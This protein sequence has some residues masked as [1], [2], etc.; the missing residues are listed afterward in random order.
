MIK[1]NPERKYFTESMVNLHTSIVCALTPENLHI[2]PNAEQASIFAQ[3]H[4]YLI[5]RRPAVAFDPGSFSFEPPLAQGYLTRKINGKESRSSFKAK[6]GT[7]PG[8]S[9]SVAPYPHR[10]ILEHDT[11]G[12]ETG[13]HFPIS[14]ICHISELEDEDIRNFEVVYVGQAFGK[15]GRSAFERLKNHSTLQRILAESAANRPD[16]ELMLFLFKYEPYQIIS[17]MDGITKDGEKGDQDT[18]HFISL[19]KNPLS[20][21]QQIALAEAG[22]IRYF[23]PEYNIVYKENFPNENQTI[24][25]QCYKLDF[26]ALSVEINT[27]DVRSRLWSPSVD[28]GVH[29]IAKFD[30][31]DIAKR[32]SFF[33]FV[34][35]DGRQHLM[36]EGGPFY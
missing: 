27:E 28:L 35:L 13:I 8:G 17:M 31:H 18:E 19:L 24:L 25:D 15:G 14:L 23:R 21:K 12:N 9:L 16:D 2:K 22:L 10:T 11:T 3:C 6:L 33:S 4:I 30:L 20:R 36:N 7:V 34:D 32:R 1:T 29:H 26:S 5:C